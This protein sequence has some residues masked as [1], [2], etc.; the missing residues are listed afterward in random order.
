MDKSTVTFWN[1]TIVFVH[2]WPK[3]GLKQPNIFRV[4]VYIKWSLYLRFVL[5]YNII[6]MTAI[7]ISPAILNC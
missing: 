7:Q 3:N 4:I 6:F 1:P 5:H 2:F